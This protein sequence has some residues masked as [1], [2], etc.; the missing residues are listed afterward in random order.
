MEAYIWKHIYG[1]PHQLAESLALKELHHEKVI[2]NMPIGRGLTKMQEKDK[3]VNAR[4]IDLLFPNLIP[5]LVS[6]SQKL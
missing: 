6:F 4:V 3:K 2:S 1:E 5:K